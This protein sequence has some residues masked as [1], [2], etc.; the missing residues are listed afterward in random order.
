MTRARTKTP[1]PSRL[2][3]RS[4]FRILHVP[5]SASGCACSMVALSKGKGAVE[6]QRKGKSRLLAAWR[7]FSDFFKAVSLFAKILLLLLQ[8]LLFGDGGTLSSHNLFENLATRHPRPSRGETARSA[9][10]AT[11]MDHPCFKRWVLCDRFSRS[12]LH[13]VIWE[14]HL[15]FTWAS[16]LSESINHVGRSCRETSRG[17]RGENRGMREL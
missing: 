8:T 9:S 16:C 4:P 6:P 5:L 2:Y 14:R 11:S 3:T 10:D 1:A 15:S 17:T 7:L 13:G 12:N